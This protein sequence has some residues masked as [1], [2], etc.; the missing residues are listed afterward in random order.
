MADGSRTRRIQ[1]LLVALNR[2]GVRDRDVLLAIAKVPRERFVPQALRPFAWD[3]RPLPIGLGQTISQPTVV[4]LM[5][6]ALRL[7]GT[8]R[9]L[10]IGTGSGYQTAILCELAGWVLTIE[11]HPALATAARRRLVALGYRNL[12]VI[13]AD[14][15]AGW[16]PAAPFDRILVTA[17]SPG[18]PT[19]LLAQLSPA[20]GARLVVPVGPP[21]GQ[22]LLVIE[23]H[24]GQLR[25]RSLG[26][27]RFVPLVFGPR[28]AGERTDG[29]AGD[30][31]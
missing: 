21:E 6:Q 9:V 22:E 20:D 28:P 8:D 24:E 3:D 1:E 10:E 5:T 7:T 29:P 23:R 14:G 26:S 2:A 27:V 31:R 11:R 12:A 18:I 13:V 30:A 15:S 16:P 17:A 25:R 19:A 4:G